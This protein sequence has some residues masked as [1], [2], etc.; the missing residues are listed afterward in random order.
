LHYGSQALSEHFSTIVARSFLDRWRVY[1]A[2]NRQFQSMIDIREATVLQNGNRWHEAADKLASVVSRVG[3]EWVEAATVELSRLQG[4]DEIALAL[5]WLRQLVFETPGRQQLEEQ[6]EQL[7]ANLQLTG[8]QRISV[9]IWQ[10]YL[11]RQRRDLSRSRTA[12]LKTLER[13]ARLGAH[14]PLAEERFFLVELISNRRMYDFLH[15]VPHI[16]Q[17]MRRLGDNGLVGSPLG[18]KNGLSRRE[19]KVLMMISEG[20]SSKLIAKSLGVTEATVK[21]HLGNIYRKLG[22]KRRREAIDAAR[23]LG[24]VS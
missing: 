6:L 18:A 13:A 17:L 3:R 24:L 20:G 1:Q 2:Q 15:T 22:C 10:A 19:T 23:A 8:R 12:L 16:R 7:L 4:R 5:A 9:E 11:F 14:G 21:Y